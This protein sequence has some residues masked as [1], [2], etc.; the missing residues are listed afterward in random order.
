MLAHVQHHAPELLEAT[1][2][3]GSQFCCSEAYIR[4]FLYA[5][6]RWVLQT[7]IHTAQKVLANANQQLW[8]LFLCLA[9][10]FRDTG[11]MHPSLFVN[12]DQT[13]VIVTDP[14]KRTIETEDVKHVGTTGKEEKRAWTAV[15]GVASDGTVLP[16]Q[17][18]M[19][20]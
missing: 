20:G 3:D 15:I 16:T 18:I 13:Q 1:A 8:D 14:T 11:I 12:F 17:V 7:S 9:L 2:G 19:K 4:K 6:M 10:I 5:N